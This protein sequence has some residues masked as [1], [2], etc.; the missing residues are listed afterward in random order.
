MYLR[1]PRDSSTNPGSMTHPVDFSS[2]LEV[3]QSTKYRGSAY[4]AQL[5]VTSNTTATLNTLQLT[6]K[7]PLY[8]RVGS[9]NISLSQQISS[10]DTTFNITIAPSFPG[11]DGVVVA[12]PATSYTIMNYTV[13]LN[14]TEIYSFSKTQT[15]LDLHTLEAP[16]YDQAE[17]LAWNTTSQSAIITAN[18][19]NI[20]IQSVQQSNFALSTMINATGYTRID[21]NATFPPANASFNFLVN[22]IPIFP[23]PDGYL[24]IGNFLGMQN[25]SI[26]GTIAA[27][28]SISL[29]VHLMT[30][31][32][33]LF[34]AM[35]DNHFGGRSADQFKFRTPDYYVKQASY[36]FHKIFNLTI[37]PAI[38]VNMTNPVSTDLAAFRQ[39]AMHTVGQSLG[40]VN[41]TWSLV[42]GTSSAN[43]G[44]DV[45]LI[46]TNHTMDHLG[47]VYG[48]SSGAFNLAINARGTQYTGNYRLPP[49][50]ADNLLQ[51]EFSHVLGAPDRFT[52][53][54]LPSVMTKPET[55]QDALNGFAT[56]TFWLEL[57]HWLEP[58][59]QTMTGVLR[60]LYW[61]V[62]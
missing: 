55:V 42:S 10:G 40:L 5:Q 26:I 43:K 57:T 58:D 31:H 13:F 60:L 32:V 29:Q 15:S 14:T 9:Q 49:S 25:F 18:N 36:Q 17:S 3:L 34:A 39:N 16:L 35:A 23:S 24:P 2:N 12:D 1:N 27:S 50:F 48:N 44:Y 54:S 59:I 62:V 61:P 7:D 4:P 53:S 38:T 11:L 56:G 28:S 45:L 22:Q 30:R 52:G 6:V 37:Y 46:F 19:G 20:T 33:V 41:D 8:N 21:L 51:H 47:I